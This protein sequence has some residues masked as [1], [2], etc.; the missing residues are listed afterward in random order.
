MN[1]G[2][3]NGAPDPETTQPEKECPICGEKMQYLPRHIEKEH[4]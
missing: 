4:K 3:P 1:G 2:N